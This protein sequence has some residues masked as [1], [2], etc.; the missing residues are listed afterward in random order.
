ML[1]NSRESS[2]VSQ[3]HEFTNL[4]TGWFVGTQLADFT[5]YLN[6][7]INKFRLNDSHKNEPKNKMKHCEKIEF[8]SSAKRMQKC[9]SVGELLGKCPLFKCEK[10]PLFWEFIIEPWPYFRSNNIIMIVDDTYR[11]SEYND[12]ESVLY[13]VVLL[14]EHTFSNR[15]PQVFSI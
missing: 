15:E 5:S 7:S 12:R 8:W 11:Y 1:S 9:T 14:C 3:P 4:Q 6:L 13:T 2:R 10:Y